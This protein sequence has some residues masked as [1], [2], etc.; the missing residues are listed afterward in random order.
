MIVEPEMAKK[1]V[2]GSEGTVAG[3]DCQT[4]ACALGVHPR[5]LIIVILQETC[6]LTVWQ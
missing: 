5:V 1:H 4:L 2:F 6:T 3:K